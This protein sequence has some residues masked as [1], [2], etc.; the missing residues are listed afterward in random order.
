MDARRVTEARRLHT[1]D[2]VL[3]YLRS[4]K[5][6]FGRSGRR[7]SDPVTIGAFL[8]IT[9]PERHIGRMHPV[10]LNSRLYSHWVNTA[11]AGVWPDTLKADQRV[12][13]FPAVVDTAQAPW[14][15]WKYK[16]TSENRPRVAWTLLRGFSF[17][18]ERDKAMVVVVSVPDDEKKPAFWTF[19]PVSDWKYVDRRRIGELIYADAEHYEPA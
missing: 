18:S 7:K 9:E 4:I 6:I 3:D 17:P 12:S 11:E 8:E 13:Y 14:E 10:V 16:T 1:L 5:S 2:E 19:M 15:V